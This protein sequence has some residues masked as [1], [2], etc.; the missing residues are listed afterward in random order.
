MQR[1]KLVY[2]LIHKI[3][4]LKVI[5]LFAGTAS[6]LFFVWTGQYLNA[7]YPT[8]EDMDMAYRV[9]LRSRHIFLLLV[10]LLEI[11][12]GVYISSADRKVFILIQYAATLSLLTAHI[13]FIYAFFYEVDVQYIPKTPVLHN[14]TYLALFSI[15]LHV[16]VS[17]E[18]ILFKKSIPNQ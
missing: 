15:I 10:S 14:A 16:S 18:G 13:L 8:K 11:G 5:Y 17:L 9:M 2:R 3:N 6:L 7:T 1:K 12:M 4:Y